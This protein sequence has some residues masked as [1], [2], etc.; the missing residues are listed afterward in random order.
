M[1]EVQAHINN[2]AF[3][4]TLEEVE[5]FIDERGN[6]DIEDILFEARISGYVEWTVPKW[7][8]VGDI[9]FFMHSK[10]SNSTISKLFSELEHTKQLYSDSSY[11]KLMK[12]LFHGKELYEQY[13]GKIFAI[14]MVDGAP[15]HDDLLIDYQQE[16]HWKSKI[17][18]KI[19]NLCCLATPI[20]ISEFRDFITI[21]RQ[22]GITPVF[23]KEYDKLK[24][25]IINKNSIPYFF[26]ESISTVI[27]LSKISMDNWIA[28]SSRYRRSFFLEI[29]FRTYYVDYFLKCLGDN[30]TFYRE[31]PCIK[32]KSQRYFADNVIKIGGKYLPVEIK[33]NITAERNL[34][35]QLLQYCMTDY[36]ILTENKTAFPENIHNNFVLVIDTFNIYLFD[37]LTCKLASIADLD[38]IK[39]ISDIAIL[40]NGLIDILTI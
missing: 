31:C 14:G 4:K 20:D 28:L 35:N 23:G 8:K 21:S 37:C 17:Y 22:S 32:N 16:L 6:F 38:E 5:W 12:A 15:F 10:T 2:I 40:K 11:D 27:P 26:K 3:P 7:A 39:H 30:K 19:S 33:L 18:A 9:V 24:Q 29:Q 36:I 1:N 25:L 34:P 13:G